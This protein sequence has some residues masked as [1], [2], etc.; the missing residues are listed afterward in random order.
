MTRFARGLLYMN[1]TTQHSTTA[2]GSIPIQDYSETW[3]S[4]TINEID[5]QLFKK[6]NIPDH[7]KQFVYK[8]I[9]QR[10]EANII[11]YK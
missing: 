8:N 10:S 2:W 6:Y 7:I 5:E 4:E 9:Q 11:N 1:K 3:W